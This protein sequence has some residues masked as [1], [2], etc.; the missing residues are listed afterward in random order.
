MTICIWTKTC[1]VWSLGGQTCNKYSNRA[2]NSMNMHLRYIQCRFLNLHEHVAH[3]APKSTPEHPRAPSS[4]PE[5]HPRAPPST[6]E[7]PRATPTIGGERAGNSKVGLEDT[8]KAPKH[9]LWT[10]LPSS[11]PQ[12]LHCQRK[13]ASP[14]R[15]LAT[16]VKTDPKASKAAC[17]HEKPTNVTPDGNPR[18]E[19]HRN[20]L[21]K[22]ANPQKPGND[23]DMVMV[24]R[25]G[26]A[27]GPTNNAMST[28]VACRRRL[29]KPSA[30]A[31]A[32][33]L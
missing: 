10:N 7:H 8:C 17:T 23:N 32:P 26:E 25:E 18:L 4:T 22:M 33:W 14:L 2:T 5:H 21:D 30:A 15:T 27:G 31:T 28:D 29:N 11:Q 9:K 19:L 1:L 20:L 24:M 6:P 3:E 12:G 16:T 13:Q